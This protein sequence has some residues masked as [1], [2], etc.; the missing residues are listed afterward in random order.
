MVSVVLIEKDDC[1]TEDSFGGIVT[2]SVCPF[3]F[4]LFISPFVCPFGFGA[5][6]I[7]DIIVTHFDTVLPIST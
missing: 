3:G 5:C 1:G 2:C 6:L 4:G 7:I